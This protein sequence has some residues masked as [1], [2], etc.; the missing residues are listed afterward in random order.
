MEDSCDVT[1][2]SS[3]GH[4]QGSIRSPRYPRHYPPSTACSYRLVGN[5]TERVQL[6]F[7]TFDLYHPGKVAEKNCLDADIVKV[8]TIIDGGKAEIDAFCGSVANPK[9]QLMSTGP[10][11]LIE[12]LSFQNTNTGT[13]FQAEYRFL[14]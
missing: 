14:Q 12:F 7:Q 2:D 9:I 1:I 10:E 8:S 6:M 13:G 5:S 3:S 4:R 11:L